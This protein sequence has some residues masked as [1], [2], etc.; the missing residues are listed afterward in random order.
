MEAH[1]GE[2]GNQHYPEET[3]PNTAGTRLL[4]SG[5]QSQFPADDIPNKTNEQNFPRYDNRT[6]EQ[7]MLHPHGTDVLYWRRP[8]GQRALCVVI[9]ANEEDKGGGVGLSSK[10][11]E[12][13][14]MDPG[15]CDIIPRTSSQFHVRREVITAVIMNVATICDVTPSRIRLSHLLLAGSLIG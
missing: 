2:R 12:A 9:T 11:P 5:T 15:N 1:E 14:V 8:V 7:H 13:F 10:L 3:R 6:T 4:S